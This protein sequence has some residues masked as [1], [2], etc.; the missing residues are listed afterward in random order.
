MYYPINYGYI[1]GVMDR[2]NEG[3]EDPPQGE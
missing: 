2:Q 3:S 1:E